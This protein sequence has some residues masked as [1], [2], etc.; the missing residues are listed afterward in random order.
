MR[1]ELI[2]LRQ[3]HRP[4]IVVKVAKQGVLLGTIT[5]CARSVDH[6][7]AFAIEVLEPTIKA[8]LRWRL[9]GTIHWPSRAQ[10]AAQV[11]DRT[12][13]TGQPPTQR[14]LI[15]PPQPIE[16]TDVGPGRSE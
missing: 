6:R 5:L 3:E 9:G 14:H 2:L 1:V 8:V 4:Q 13:W 16:L 11:P 12:H 7:Q 10:R 15:L